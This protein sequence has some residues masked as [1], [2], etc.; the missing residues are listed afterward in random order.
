MPKQLKILLLT[1]LLLAGYPAATWLVLNFY[2]D[3]PA[4]MVWTDRE[5]YNRK[6][7][8][9]LDLTRQPGQSMV[10]QKLGG[11]DI[12]EAFQRDGQLYQL[13][14]YRTQRAISDGITTKAECTALLYLDRQVIA[15]GTAAEQ[16]YQRQ[17]NGN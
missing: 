8:R 17:K 9:Q 4:E 7:I 5:A 3:D 12:S 16:L 13:A 10:Q 1:V 15:V 14:Y 6:F 11:P 2:Q